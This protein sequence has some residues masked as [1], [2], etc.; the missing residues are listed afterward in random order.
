MG[1][2]LKVQY[3]EKRT[4]HIQKGNPQMIN[5]KAIGLVVGHYGGA[6]DRGIWFLTEMM[7]W[8]HPRH[9]G[10]KMESVS[11]FRPLVQVLLATIIPP[12]Q[13]R[14]IHS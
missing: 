5:E 8:Q 7:N 14:R 4:I 3:I 9:L 11:R 6:R 12:P 1:G 2:R 10:T 13:H